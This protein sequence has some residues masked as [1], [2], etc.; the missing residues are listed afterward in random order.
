MVKIG[1][2]IRKINQVMAR[3]LEIKLRLQT[4]LILTVFI[5]IVIG[6]SYSATLR[7][8]HNFYRDE[9]LQTLETTVNQITGWIEDYTRDRPADYRSLIGELEF[10]QGVIAYFNKAS[11]IEDIV[12]MSILDADFESQMDIGESISPEIISLIRANPSH[13]GDIQRLRKSKVMLFSSPIMLDPGW[14]T[15][16]S[17]RKPEQAMGT[18]VLMMSLDRLNREFLWVLSWLLP[19][20]LFLLLLSLIIQNFISHI[21]LSPFKTLLESTRR[22]ASGDYSIRI[23]SR[24]IDELGVLSQAFDQMAD[25]LETKIS[26]L[27]VKNKELEESKEMIVQQE[28]LASLGTMVAGIA[29]E[30]NNPAQAIKFS[31]DSLKMDIQDLQ[32]LFDQSRPDSSIVP[33][34]WNRICQEMMDIIQENAQSV[35]RIENIVKSTKRMAYSD[36]N[37]TTCMINE[38]IHDAVVLAHSQIKYHLTLKMDLGENLPS[39]QGSP[40]ELGQL[41]INLIINSKDA[42]VEKGLSPE[43]GILEI[44]SRFLD[45]RGVLEIIFRDNGSGI[46][47]ENL[48]QI[49]DPFF[50]TKLIGQGTGL[51]LYLSHRMIESHHGTITVQSE[52]GRGTVFSVFLPINLDMRG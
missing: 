42:I 29:H 32:T 16:P 35:S 45:D 17:L 52:V 22:F 49:F 2:L 25:E 38:I 41:F 44:R 40:Q 47:K 18:I 14:K 51:G 10:Q 3:S 12:G 48:S 33:E 8:I 30:I 6:L 34:E 23:G 7:I 11:L 9:G 39:I 4:G 46:K 31:L 37:M 36:L 21:L 13:R 50:T 19:A 26:T 15:S 5:L 43:D 1:A 24:R 20:I 27:A 28:K